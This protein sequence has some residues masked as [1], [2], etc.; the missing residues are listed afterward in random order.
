LKALKPSISDGE[1]CVSA[2]QQHGEKALEHT[3]RNGQQELRQ[4]MTTAKDDWREAVD[5]LGEQISAL[6]SRMQEWDELDKCCDELNDWLTKTEAQLKNIAMKT[7]VADK[8]TVVTQLSVSFHG[9]LFN[10]CDYF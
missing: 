10:S 7:A 5:S 2:I 3:G 6:E 1:T 4:Q 9:I 8:Q